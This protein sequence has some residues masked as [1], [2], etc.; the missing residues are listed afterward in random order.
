MVL[1]HGSAAAQK[2]AQAHRSRRRRRKWRLPDM[3]PLAWK[4]VG[5][6]V[7]AF[8]L[9]VLGPVILFAE[10][11]PTKFVVAPPAQE[12]ETALVES[13]FLPSGSDDQKAQPPDVTPQERPEPPR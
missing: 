6:Y 3:S 10:R 2:P 13:P 9:A 8:G 11:A 1:E 7:V 4:K 12:A 5:V